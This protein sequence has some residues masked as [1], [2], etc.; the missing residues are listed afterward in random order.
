MNRT[1]SEAQREA[2]L[3]K[4]HELIGGV[5][6]TIEHPTKIGSYG[7]PVAQATMLREAREI[8]G[9]VLSDSE[10]D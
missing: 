7:T 10:P 4:V 6:H 5:L 1:T 3:Q 8:L 9:N 2:E